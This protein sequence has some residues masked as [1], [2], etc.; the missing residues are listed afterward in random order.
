[1]VSIRLLE[2]L[3][4]NARRF[5]NEMGAGIAGL[6]GLNTG[7]DLSVQVLRGLRMYLEEPRIKLMGAFEDDAL[8][9]LAMASLRDQFAEVSY[10]H[11]LPEA[12]ERG[13]DRLLL[14]K[15]IAHLREDCGVPGILAEFVPFYESDLTGTFADMG[16]KALDRELMVADAPLRGMARHIS[17]PLLP[18]QFREAAACL[19][20][21]YDGHPSRPLHREFHFEDDA[22]D[23]VHRVEAGFYGPTT[24]EGMRY[25]RDGSGRMAA[26][27][28]STELLPKLGF[29]LQIATRPDCQNQGYGA[30]L[31]HAVVKRFTGLGITRLSLGVSTNNP[32]R[33]LYRKLGYEKARPFTSH[34]WWRE[35][36]Q[37]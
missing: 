5:A 18:G 8:T 36:E 17:Y 12:A 37:P 21:A 14:S 24:A 25:C 33:E 9:A 20:A 29:V 22:L 1:M 34:Y 4:S 10:V 11:A 27:I 35:Q 2:N 7:T 30:S 3:P 28:L 15:L 19:V 32:A 13:D 23:Y 31:I 26:V 16:F 6:Y